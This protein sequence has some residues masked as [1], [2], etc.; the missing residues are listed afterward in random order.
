LTKQPTNLVI[1][2]LKV[3]IAVVVVLV[4]FYFIAF[5]DVL[6]RFLTLLMNGCL[7][8]L[9]FLLYRKMD[10]IGPVN[11]EGK[12][13]F[14]QS[15]WINETEMMKKEQQ[16]NKLELD[17][18]QLLEELLTRANIGEEEKQMYRLRIREKE[19][20]ASKLKQELVLMKDRV[21]HLLLKRDPEMERIVQILGAE[22]IL[23]SSFDELNQK[24]QQVHIQLSD[25]AIRHLQRENYID[26]HL[27]FT[28]IGYRELLKTAKR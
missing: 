1:T 12:K 20:E 23:N 24:F 25:E 6:V 18:T 28:R 13:E 5:N 4:L 21:A 14:V 19:N 10:R 26:E 9:V 17:K 15:D 8:V 2:L 7:V 22:F 16:L 27:Q 3:L 11:K